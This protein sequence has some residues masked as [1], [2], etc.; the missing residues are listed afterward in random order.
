[1]RYDISECV[2]K[3]GAAKYLK[4]LRDRFTAGLYTKRQFSF[5]AAEAYFLI[6]KPLRGLK[7]LGSVGFAV[8]TESNQQ[9]LLSFLSNHHKR[10]RSAGGCSLNMIVKDEA[11]SIAAA[12]DSVDALM[13][14]IVVCDTGSED[15]TREIAMLYGATVLSVPWHDDFSAARNEAIKASTREWIFWMDADDRLGRESRGD[16]AALISEGKPQAAAFCIVN[17]QNGAAGARFMQ[18]RLFPRQE[19]LYFERR[20]HE[21]IMFSARRC[22]VPFTRYPAIKIIHHGYNDPSVQKR[23]AARN[24]RLIELELEDHPRDAALRLNYGDCLLALGR[25]DHA[26]EAYCEIA[27]N[28]EL[29][30]GHPDVYVQAHFNLGCICN[31]KKDPVMAKRW[32]ANCIRMDNTRIEAYFMLGRIF[33]GENDLEHALECYV[34]ASRIDPPERLTAADNVRTRLESIYRVANI[35]MTT[36]RA[37]EAENLLEAAIESFPKVVEYHALLG[38]ARLG[39]QKLREA[40]RSFMHSLSLSPTNNKEALSGMAVIYNKLNDPVKERMFLEMAEKV[41]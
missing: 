40:A 22:N 2:R 13:D 21:Q 19:G 4:A 25:V 8:D 16:L 3:F 7:L 30:T 34:K 11:A 32:L 38:R 6:N 36:G 20:I 9:K 23:K 33:E 10:P 26:Q 12:L 41:A 27:K 39:Q 29:L 35:L 17:E 1:M 24:V 37:R 5:L 14:E 31:H 18:V 15:G 28:S